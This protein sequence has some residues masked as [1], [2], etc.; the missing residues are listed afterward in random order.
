M[1][2]HILRLLGKYLEIYKENIFN[3]FVRLEK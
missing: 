1:I 2:A 3:T